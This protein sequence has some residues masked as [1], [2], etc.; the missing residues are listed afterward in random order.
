MNKFNFTIA[1]SCI[2]FLLSISLFSCDSEDSYV[3]VTSVTLNTT[4][5]NI[6]KGESYDLKATVSPYNATNKNLIWFSSDASIADVMKGSVIAKKSGQAIITVQTDDGAKTATCSV[7]VTEGTD[8]ETS[9]GNDPVTPDQPYEPETK[10]YKYFIMDG[11]GNVV[12]PNRED[13]YWYFQAAVKD[14]GKYI[15]CADNVFTFTEVEGG[16]TIQDA[17][18]YYYMSGNLFDTSKSIPKDNNRHIWSIDLQTDGT[19]AIINKSNGNIIQNYHYNKCI[20]RDYYR[21][22]G[23]TYLPYLVKVEKVAV[24]HADNAMNYKYDPTDL[25]YTINGKP[26]EMIYVEGDSNINSFYI[27]QTEIPPTCTFQ[28]EDEYIGMLDNNKDNIVSRNEFTDFVWRIWAKTKLPFRLPT[29]KEWLYAAKGGCKSKNY[30]YSGSNSIDEVAWYEGNSSSMAHEVAKKLP[31]ELGL[32][33]MSGNYEEVCAELGVQV[34]EYMSKYLN[35]DLYGGRWNDLASNCT[36]T[37]RRYGWIS[38]PGV[39]DWDHNSI[40]ARYMTIRLVYALE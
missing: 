7:I 27:M 37:S 35:G 39:P 4:H 17:D 31:N 40:D 23:T 13:G 24:K 34:D 12:I 19:S 10:S 30:K 18:G 28:I 20:P 16:Y 36:T 1:K 11:C 3:A 6:S 15:G 5:I 25:S 8:G 22:D 33:D 2:V 29:Y 32:Y 9:G 21:E 14:G 26:Y 38:R